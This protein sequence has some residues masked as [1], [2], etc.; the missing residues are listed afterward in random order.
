MLTAH[1]S[2]VHAM[3]VPVR[4][5]ESTPALWFEGRETSFGEVDRNSN[6]VAH[7]L[8]AAGVKP[9]DSVATLMKNS[10]DFMVILLGVLKARACLVP[11]NWRLAI[12]EISHIIVDSGVKVL[13]CEPRLAAVAT[14]LA[15]ECP[16]LSLIVQTGGTARQHSLASW[17]SEFD[18]GEL[19]LDADRHEGVLQLYTSGTTGAP[20]GVRLSHHN[21]LSFYDS[22]IG[23]GWAAW[24]TGKTSLLTFPLYHIAGFNLYM[25]AWLQGVRSLLVADVDPELIARL[26]DEQRVN[27]ASMV[28]AVLDAVI[29]VSDIR[30]VDF[31]SVEKISYGGAPITEDLLSRALRS[32]SCAFSQLYGMTETGGG[33]TE[34]PPEAHVP[35]L[36]RSCGRALPGIDIRI[37][38]AAGLGCAP[39]EHGEIQIRTPSMIRSYWRR[40]DLAPLTPDGWFAT[41][42]AGYVNGDGYYFLCD[43][44]KDM[45]ISGGENIYPAEIE[46]ALAG[47][48]DIADVAVIGVPDARWGEAVKAFIVLRPGAATDAQAILAWARGIIAGFK[49]PKSIEFIPALPR[50]ATGKVLRRALRKG[51]FT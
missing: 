13:C 10:A 36:L 39:S 5:R 23:S 34:L 38:N 19:P 40:P 41:G 17:L 49:L 28:P 32:F 33:A 35:A 50:N 48:P 27:Y 3:R 44:I 1:E 22:A 6:R 43:R 7:A 21:L 18:D 51:S 2:L 37:V 25:L 8:I 47:H 42:D 20:K 31:G 4:E 24:E 30:S 14:T 12:P 45:I 15:N 11:I 9:G 46:N 16:E 29:G 26:I